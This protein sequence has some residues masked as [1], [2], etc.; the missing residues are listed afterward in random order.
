MKH[1][2]LLSAI[3]VFMMTG[4]ECSAYMGA[5]PV[6]SSSGHFSAVWG[7]LV[8][9]NRQPVPFG[10]I[11]SNGR[12][13]LADSG[14]R[15]RIEPLNAGKTT[16]VVEA[17]GYRPHKKTYS[18][19][20]GIN[21]LDIVL[22][23]MNYVNQNGVDKSK[24]HGAGGAAA[25]EST[26]MN[27]MAER[28]QDAEKAFV[29]PDWQ[30]MC[31]SH[32]HDRDE[33]KKDKEVGDDGSDDFISFEQMVEMLDSQLQAGSISGRVLDHTG[34]GIA[35]AIVRIG[36]NETITGMEGE[37]EVEHLE[38]GDWGIICKAPGFETFTG[39]GRVAG[40]TA[41]DI[42]MQGSGI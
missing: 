7:R 24:I 1:K 37:Y 28:F 40:A 18:L 2:L 39:F 38:E 33:D 14:G 41:M 5:W 21:G 6:D 34:A 36:N 32:L 42:V 26:A 10:S 16:I 29:A 13:I 19:R 17:E 23:R 8:N 11:T 25:V 9:R 22:H 4:V 31:L 12:T 15:F 27:E 20:R 30:K 3:I 35:G